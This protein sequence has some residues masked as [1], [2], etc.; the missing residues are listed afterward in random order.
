MAEIQ[1]NYG[2][3]VSKVIPSVTMEV[4][5]GVTLICHGQEVEKGQKELLENMF[6]SVGPVKVIVEDCF[7]VAHT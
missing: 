5:R 1:Q 6:G 4:G 3:K 2:L 7:D